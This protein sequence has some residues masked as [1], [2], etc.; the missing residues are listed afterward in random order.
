MSGNI[1][2]AIKYGKH[3]IFPENYP[4]SHPFIIPEK[5]DLEE[6]IFND[7]KLMNYDFEEN[8]AREKVRKNLEQK[9][10]TLL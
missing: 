1:G 4:I 7:Q 5:K 3:A 8:F 10:L 6:Q 2:D 9:L